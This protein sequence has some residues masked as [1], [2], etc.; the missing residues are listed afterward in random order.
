V[1]RVIGW[2]EWIATLVHMNE[3]DQKT[4]ARTIAV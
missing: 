1:I 3:N 4:M 2:N